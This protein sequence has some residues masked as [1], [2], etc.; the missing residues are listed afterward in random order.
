M[1]FGPQP[2]PVAAEAATVLEEVTN[3]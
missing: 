1:V 3:G 2:D